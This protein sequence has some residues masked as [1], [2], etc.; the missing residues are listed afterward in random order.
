[1]LLAAAPGDAVDAYLAETGGAGGDAAGL[2]TAWGLSL[3]LWPRLCLYLSGLLHFD[4]GWSVAFDRPVVGLILER[5]P[6]TLLLSGTALAFAAALGTSMG[7]L[8][9]MR[10]HGIGDGILRALS[11]IL[12]A[13]PNFWLGLM[14]MLL[15]TLKLA[16]LPLGGIS[17]LTAS[18]GSL[19]HVLDVAKH[20][21]LPVSAL[22]L[23]YAAL[24]Q[25]LMRAGMVQAAG[26]DYVRT[27][28]AKGLA[29]RRILLRHMARNAILP[30][31]TMLGLQA[32]T[33]LGGSVVIESVFAIPGLGRL[34]AEAVTRRDAPLLL[35][36]IL[37]SALLVILINVLIDLVQSKLDPRVVRS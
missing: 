18:E 23:G 22:G 17:S 12:S 37:I 33:L 7:I 1:M 13:I 36:I 29:R 35:G 5:L 10:P 9:G 20:L 24:Y 3:G 19:S 14:L 15:F 34:A 28:R 6:N 16:W 26:E 32:G 4:L 31:V 11:L 2:R 25:R 27:A 21:V 8:A 30:V